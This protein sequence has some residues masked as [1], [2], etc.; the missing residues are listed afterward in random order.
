MRCP[1]RTRPHRPVRAGASAVH[2][3]P[4][5]RTS[6]CC[7]RPCR[8]QDR[9]PC[10]RVATSPSARVGYSSVSAAGYTEGTAL[11]PAAGITTAGQHSWTRRL[12]NGRPQDTN[13]NLA[14]FQ[15][16]ATTG[17]T[18]NGV[19][20]VLGAPG[21]QRGPTMTACTTT[22]AP[23]GHLAEIPQTL[24]DPLQNSVTAPNKSVTTRRSP[25]ARSARSRSAGASPTTRVCRSS[26][27]A[28][29]STRSTR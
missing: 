2:K 13:N 24:I 18:I 9:S 1:V 21:P 15:L 10:R 27:C 12:S 25:T 5:K 7:R 14:D 3:V 11:A 26:R 29:A 6:S 19:A 28:S 23:I 16:V 17:N 8:P 22:S 20:A 4:P